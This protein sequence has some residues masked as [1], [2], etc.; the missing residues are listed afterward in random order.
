VGE[1]AKIAKARYLHGDYVRRCG[2]YK[3]EGHASYP[4]RSA[5]LPL[6]TAVVKQS[7][8]TAEFSRG[9]SR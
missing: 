2:V 6:A 4:G 8:G 7:D 1:V 9:H 3:C 5:V